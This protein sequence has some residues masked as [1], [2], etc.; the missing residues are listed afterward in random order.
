[1]L[2]RVSQDAIDAVIEPAERQL[3]QGIFTIL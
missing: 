3:I 2:I 1:M